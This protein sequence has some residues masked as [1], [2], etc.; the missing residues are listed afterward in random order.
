MPFEAEL[1]GLQ[2]EINVQGEALGFCLEFS[3]LVSWVCSF[4]GLFLRC[5]GLL[6][7]VVKGFLSFFLGGS[8]RLCLGFS[9]FLR[10]FFGFS[11]KEGFIV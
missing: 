7:V 9:V 3:G 10:Y 6:K 4:A 8:F 2:G 5:L 1:L 11:T